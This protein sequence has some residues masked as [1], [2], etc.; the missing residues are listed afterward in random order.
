MRMVKFLPL[1]KI[2]C[3]TVLGSIT[4]FLHIAK[5]TAI[6]ETLTFHRCGSSGAASSPLPLPAAPP[7]RHSTA[8]DLRPH[9]GGHRACCP[10]GRGLGTMFRPPAQWLFPLQNERKSTHQLTH[11]HSNI[12]HYSWLLVTNEGDNRH[13]RYTV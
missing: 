4:A 6:A 3:Y 13:V 5:S 8:P 12:I 9:S 1:A 7:C 10:G 11:T 2:S